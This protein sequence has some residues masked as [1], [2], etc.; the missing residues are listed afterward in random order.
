QSLR[1]QVAQLQA[2]N[3]GLS[4][5]LAQ[6]RVT[7]APRLP[8]PPLQASEP[9]NP[10]SAE[11]MQITN[12]YAQLMAKNPPKLSAQQV[13]PYLDANR[14]NAASLLAAFRTTG[15]SNLLE[16]A[17][18][19]FPNDPQVAFEAVIKKEASSAERRQWL[20]AFKQSAPDN[21]LVNY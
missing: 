6:A 18:Q 20:D 3:G 11:A 15:D 21:A 5:R 12:L 17:M 7:R 19:K 14:R 8:A 2:D 13:A 1:Q 16:E 4:A 9:L 10:S